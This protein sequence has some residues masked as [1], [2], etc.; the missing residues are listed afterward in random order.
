MCVIKN[1]SDCVCSRMAVMCVIK[2]GSDV[3]V[4]RNDSD[5]CIQEWQ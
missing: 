5:V 3:C 1:G 4:F 2:N